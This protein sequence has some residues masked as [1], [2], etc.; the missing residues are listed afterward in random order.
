MLDSLCRELRGCLNRKMIKSNDHDDQIKA[1]SLASSPL[2]TQQRCALPVEAWIQKSV[3]TL[4][5]QSTQP[6]TAVTIVPDHVLPEQYQSTSASLPHWQK[7]PSYQCFVA[8]TTPA[9]G[10]STKSPPAYAM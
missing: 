4:T 3:A 10:G 6:V 7:G 9:E 8:E 1:A 2:H 5:L